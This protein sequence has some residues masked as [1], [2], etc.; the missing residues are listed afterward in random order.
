M[1]M[2]G[3]RLRWNI[4]TAL[5]LAVMAVIYFKVKPMLDEPTLLATAPVP[6]LCD[7]NQTVCTSRLEGIGEIALA[8]SPRPVPVLKPLEV[9]VESRID[10]VRSIALRVTGRNM[11]MGVNQ[12]LLKPQGGNGYRGEAML[13]VCVR[14]RM[15]W[16][17]EVVVE[18]GHGQ[19]IF[20]FH[21]ETVTGR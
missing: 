7:L 8:L 12:F 18:T 15:E 1:A 13:P 17:A 16:L 14:D 10:D 3:N 2:R 9:R 4:L 19:L 11:N 21:F 20:P 5:L 6:T